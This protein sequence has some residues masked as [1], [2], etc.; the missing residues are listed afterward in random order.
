MAR[1]TDFPFPSEALV[2]AE[3]LFSR[4]YSIVVGG[5]DFPF[6]SEALV[7][8]EYHIGKKVGPFLL[9]SYSIVV[10]LV[11]TWIEAVVLIA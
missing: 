1:G 11:M 8:A 4:D 9:D 6:P 7:F 5:T 2:F 10:V 3:Y